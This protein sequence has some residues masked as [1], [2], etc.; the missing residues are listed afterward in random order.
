M[1][2]RL[3]NAIEQSKELKKIE[4]GEISGNTTVDT[5][6]NPRYLV[7]FVLDVRT[8]FA[9]NDLFSSTD[10]VENSMTTKNLYDAFYP[11]IRNKIKPNRSNLPDIQDAELLFLYPDGAFIKDARGQ[12]ILTQRRRSSIP[13]IRN[14]NR[15]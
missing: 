12:H 7:K 5:R 11:L 13:W 2:I 6:G 9:D 15:L 3:F 14:N 1:Y 8:Y 4:S 10:Y